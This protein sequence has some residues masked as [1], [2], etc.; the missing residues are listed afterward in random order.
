MVAEVSGGPRF[1]EAEQQQRAAKLS[2]LRFEGCHGASGVL[3]DVVP[4]VVARWRRWWLEQR[5]EEGTLCSIRVQRVPCGGRL[6]EDAERTL[7]G[8]AI[9]GARQQLHEGQGVRA[10]RRRLQRVSVRA[11]DQRQVAKHWRARMGQLAAAARNV[12]SVLSVS[13]RV[14]RSC[15]SR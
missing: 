10:C 13:C 9:G 6:T 12:E 1:R 4:H 8:D 15:D 2:G 11:V 14:A 3:E 7:L 5:R